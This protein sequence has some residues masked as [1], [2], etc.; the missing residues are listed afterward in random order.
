MK[1]IVLILVLFTFS[2]KVTSETIIK[3]FKAERRLKLQSKTQKLINSI[4]YIE[5]R[6]NPSAVNKKEDAVGYL[7]IRKI[8]L[9]EAN[10]ILGYEKYTLEDRFSIE[11]SIEIFITVQKFHNPKLD[12][13]IAC[14]I[15]NEGSIDTTNIN[16][17]PYWKKFKKAYERFNRT[18]SKSSKNSDIC[19]EI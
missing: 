14:M 6:H 17:K 16:N 5:S 10:R 11:K 9:R 19:I 4:S 1:K 8:M 18:Y 13:K 15:W 12:Y 2:F 7:Q 3:T